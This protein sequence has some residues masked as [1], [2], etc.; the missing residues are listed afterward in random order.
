MTL[1]PLYTPPP[2]FDA[3]VS[4][5]FR[6]VRFLTPPYRTFCPTSRWNEIHP[7]SKHQN[8]R[9][10]Q[11]CEPEPD[12]DGLEEDAQ[13]GEDGEGGGA[14]AGSSASTSA[15]A[16]AA[17]TA[18]AEAAAEAFKTGAAGGGG[19]A[20]GECL[21]EPM[22]RHYFHMNLKVKRFFPFSDRCWWETLTT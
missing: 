8:P 16:V 4:I 15:A 3:P 2:R 14:A 10:I 18:A 20:G 6:P 7:P 19:A 11:D 12:V 21:W 13:G 17:A 9:A 5:F 1:P 22:V